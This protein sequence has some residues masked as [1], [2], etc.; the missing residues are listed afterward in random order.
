MWH[1]ATWNVIPRRVLGTLSRPFRL[2]QSG[3]GSGPRIR[4]DKGTDQLERRKARFAALCGSQQ[5]RYRW[6]TSVW[7]V[8][9][10]ITG[11]L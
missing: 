7:K 4:R 6:E 5:D 2:A 10:E 1:R 8:F 3:L 11:K 9:A